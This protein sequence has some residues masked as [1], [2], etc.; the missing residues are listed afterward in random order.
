MDVKSFY[1]IEF[2]LFFALIPFIFN[3]LKALNLN[4]LFYRDQ[5]E[6]IKVLFFVITIVL[7][8]LF[9]HAIANIVRL[10]YYILS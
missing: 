2:C 1:I 7:S 3:S 8:Y 5:V 6:R 9:S 4:N 10:S